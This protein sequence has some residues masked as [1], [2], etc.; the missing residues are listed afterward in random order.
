[1]RC[2]GFENSENMN[3]SRGSQGYIGVALKSAVVLLRFRIS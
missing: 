2:S 3:P 1:M